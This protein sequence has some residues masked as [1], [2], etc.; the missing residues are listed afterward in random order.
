M[1]VTICYALKLCWNFVVSI[2]LAAMIDFFGFGFTICS[3]RKLVFW[4]SKLRINWGYWK[5]MYLD[6]MLSKTRLI[7]LRFKKFFIYKKLRDFAW[8]VLE[9][10]SGAQS[11]LRT[12]RIFRTW[13]SHVFWPKAWIDAQLHIS[14]KTRTVVACTMMTI[15]RHRSHKQRRLNVTIRAVCSCAGYTWRA[16]YEVKHTGSSMYVVWW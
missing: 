7:L 4:R 9:I 6:S 15:N 10:T 1:Y 12:W 16:W 3:D 2:L 13:Q 8:F 14:K 11:N 5:R